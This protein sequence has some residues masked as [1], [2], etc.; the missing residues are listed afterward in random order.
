M[1]DDWEVELIK[2]REAA[3]ARNAEWEQRWPIYCRGCGG[4]G[5]FTFYQSHGPGPS[6]QMS[7]PCDAREPSMCHRCGALGL[8]E[9]GDGPCRECGWN[10]DDG[11]EMM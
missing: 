4:W 9:D 3:D 5:A 10:Y 2:A 8:S 7:E 1:N 11:L 6:E